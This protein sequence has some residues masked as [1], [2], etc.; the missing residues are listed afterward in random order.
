MKLKSYFSG[1]VEAAME[2]ARQELGDEAL[3]INA[4]PATPET[5]SLG[6]YEVVFGIPP[7]ALDAAP[8]KT[9][10]EPSVAAGAATLP[11]SISED[12]RL[13]E[14]VA[15]LKREIQRLAESLQSAGVIAPQPEV[16]ESA[17]QSRLI[18]QELD[19][20]LAKTVAH[21]TPIENLFEVDSTLGRPGASRAVVALIGPP[22]SGKTTALIQI[23]ARCAFRSLRPVQILSADVH[24]IAAADQLRSLASILG[25]GC[26]IVETPLAL[27]QALEE[28]RSKSMVLID[29]PGLARQ[30]M[31]DSAGLA[32][33][34]A[35]HPEIDTHL[36]LAA[37]MKPLDMSRTVDSYGI[38]APR[39][40]LFTRIDE[41]S[42]YGALVSEA[43][44]R[45]LPISF[46]AAGQRI[47]DDFEPATKDRLAKLVL[48]GETTLTSAF[49]QRSVGATA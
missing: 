47:P 43:A 3:L 2:L 12:H 41:T 7:H 38:F 32:E 26:D 46:L 5:R 4:R 33:L 42:R 18:A 21:G 8:V 6:A 49:I 11:H 31:E 30:E 9:A 13:I 15:Q 27:A 48:D 23:A 39:K 10:A 45:S 24:R 40:F 16:H 19:Q 20:E 14:D 28:H 44:R 34:I 22:G 1:T 36:V 17:T 29:T 35:A 25:I 37:S